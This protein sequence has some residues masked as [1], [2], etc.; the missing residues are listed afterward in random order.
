KNALMQGEE[1]R[2]PLRGPHP[3]ELTGLALVPVEIARDIDGADLDGAFALPVSAHILRQHVEHPLLQIMLVR[4]GLRR[5][6]LRHGGVVIETVFVLMEGDA[7]DEHGASMLDALDTTGGEATAIPDA[8]DVVD[9]G[10]GG[11]TGKEEV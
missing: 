2:K 9:D 4:K 1:I 3:D 6:R 7:H 8:L 5:R 10:L 11:V